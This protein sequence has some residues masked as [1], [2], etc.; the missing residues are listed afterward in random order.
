MERPDK[1]F[2]P[3]DI[4]IMGFALEKRKDYNMKFIS[5][6]KFHDILEDINSNGLNG[7]IKIRFI[8]NVKE[9]ESMKCLFL[10]ILLIA[11]DISK[12]CLSIWNKYILNIG[13]ASI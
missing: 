3:T 7:K 4:M 8:V 11:D 9:S 2:D 5:N 6:I 10:L 13:T 12:H 1:Y